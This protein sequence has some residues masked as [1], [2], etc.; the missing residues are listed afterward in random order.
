MQRQCVLGRVQSGCFVCYYI[1]VI[2]EW[3]ISLLCYICTSTLLCYI[4]T[5]TWTGGVSTLWAFVDGPSTIFLPI[6]VGHFRNHLIFMHFLVNL[7]AFLI[8]DEMSAMIP[9][10]MS[11]LNKSVP[12]TYYIENNIRN[13]I[14]TKIFHWFLSGI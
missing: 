7:L 8:E 11:S 2:R 1:N 6:S 12:C 5:S 10:D 9:P 4:C 13:I 3:F 14:L